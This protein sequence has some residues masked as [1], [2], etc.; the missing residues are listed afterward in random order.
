MLDQDQSDR[1][2]TLLPLVTVIVLAYNGREHLRVC[3]PTVLAQTYPADRTEVLVVDN[4]SSD[5]SYEEV[6][7]QFPSVRLMRN[8]LNYGFARGNN[9]GARVARGEYV[10]FLNQDTRADRHWLA[11]LMA[12]IL[13]ARRTGDRDLVCTGAKMLSW[14]GQVIDFAGGRMN[15]TGKATQIGAGQPDGPDYSIERETLFACGGAMLIDR[16]VFLNAGGFDDDYFVLFEDVD[17]GWRLWVLGYRIMF[18]PKAIVYHRLHAS[19]GQVHDVHKQLIFE[20]NALFSILKNYDDA[21]LGRVLP[22]SLLLTIYRVL[23]ELREAGL[24]RDDYDIRSGNRHSPPEV[25]LSAPGASLLLALDEVLERLPGLFE[26]RRVIQARRRRSDAAIAPLFGAPLEPLD[27]VAGFSEASFTLMEGLAIDA[28]VAAVG[29]RVMIVSLDML[30]TSGR[31]ATLIAA[32]SQ[33][34]HALIGAVHER[35][36]ALH[37]G[38]AEPFPIVTWSETT[39]PT[40]VAEQRPDALLV[41]DWQPAIWLDPMCQPVRI[42]TIVDLAAPLAERGPW[43]PAGQ[44][45]PAAGTLVAA[46]GAVD[47]VICATEEVVASFEPWLTKAGFDLTGPHG[48]PL[49]VDESQLGTAGG[50]A[51]IDRFLR[52]PRLRPRSPI[53][54]PL[55]VTPLQAAARVVQ[56]APANGP[57]GPTGEAGTA[58]GAEG[59]AHPPHVAEPMVQPSPNG[60][61]MSGSAWPERLS[62]VVPTYDRPDMLAMVLEGLAAQ[63]WPRDRLEIIVIDDGGALPAAP[64]VEAVAA[65]GLPVTSER[66]ANAGPAAARNRGIRR[67]TGQVVVFL[68]DD[69]VPRPTWLAEHAGGHRRPGLVTTGP[70]AWHPSVRVTPLLR[71]AGERTLFNIDLV[72]VPDDAPFVTFYTANAAVDRDLALAA[73]LF[74]EEFTRAA[75]EDT[76]FAYRLRQAGAR[77]VFRP[78]AVVEHLRGF[79]LAGFLRRERVAGYEAVRAWTKHPE[80]RSMIGMQPVV[81]DQIEQHFFESAGRYA[82]LIGAAEA[83]GT[84][85]PGA[86]ILDTLLIHAGDEPDLERWRAEYVREREREMSQE[87]ARQQATI[88]ELFGNNDRLQKRLKR[89]EAELA[90]ARKR[91]EDLHVAYQAQNLWA[92]EMEA[93]LKLAGSG[94]GLVA[95]TLA[96]LRGT[97]VS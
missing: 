91:H 76:E 81:G 18:A 52:Q 95:R 17:L 78:E 28:G 47:W 67:A 80:L 62:V 21:N 65:R 3:L 25:L 8:P 16:Q 15:V 5:G 4:A 79:D 46:L 14:D 31:T 27:H 88:N 24:Q 42:P 50:F 13:A 10:A 57:G 45:L 85:G 29:R 66:Q 43:S 20:R 41:V 68:D 6:Q 69:C 61:S 2:A 84:D 72:S 32:L 75:W 90:E 87:Y 39:L 53:G 55:V 23:A 33:A 64:V 73:G 60:T 1:S 7:E 83:L 12:P 97:P 49:V 26:R 58:T 22:A 89:L 86:S 94:T 48:R 19:V 63:T 71:F 30:P 70:I 54:T 11:E 92:R 34:G 9:I 37:P 51:P 36:R 59:S 74:D 44:V 96:R 56:A 35:S 77:F 40:V 93:R 38:A 82:W